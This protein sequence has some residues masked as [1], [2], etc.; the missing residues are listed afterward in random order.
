MGLRDLLCESIALAL[1]TGLK[2][3]W[4]NLAPIKVV[5]HKNR[6]NKGRAK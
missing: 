4:A 5:G 3:G 2:F 6:F 1:A